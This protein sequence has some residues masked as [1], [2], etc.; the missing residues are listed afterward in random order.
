M[1]TITK[2]I[3]AA[4]GDYA[5]PAL[6]A[7]AW[8]AGTISG[9]S[10]ADDIVFEIGD[11]TRFA[12]TFVVNANPTNYASLR[13]TTAV[14]VRHNGTLGTGGGLA[15]T[16]GTSGHIVHINMGT[17]PVPATIEWL[18]ITTN[19]AKLNSGVYLQTVATGGTHTVRNN[20]IY[21]NG[22]PAAADCPGV[23]VTGTATDVHNNLIANWKSQS[24]AG[25]YAIWLSAGTGAVSRRFYNNT[26]YDI[27]CSG[28]GT[29]GGIQS[30][31]TTFTSQNNVIV[32][33][34]TTTSG[35]KNCIGGSV[36]ATRGYNATT[37]TTATGT[38]AITSIVEADTFANPGSNDF[39]PKNSASIY[40]TGLDL[41]T[42]PS[43]VQTDLKAF[44]RDTSGLAWSI[45]AYQE[46]STP[47]D[48]ISLTSPVDNQMKQRE[49]SG[50]ASFTLTGTY[51][52]AVA[53]GGIQYRWAGGA[54]TTLVATPTSGT[55]SQAVTLATGQG[56]L[57]VRLT[58]ATSV[59][60]S[61]TFVT[62]GDIYAIYGQSNASGRGVSN[63]TYSGSF[64]SVQYTGNGWQEL[65]DPADSDSW[66]LDAV[67]TDSGAAG[68][69]WCHKMVTDLM[70]DLGVPV[71]VLIV[72]KGGTSIT[73]FKAGADHLDRST[74][75]GSLN[76]HI[77]AIGGVKCV[78]WWQGETDAIAAMSQATYNGHLDSIANDLQTDRGIKL[79][80]CLL[81]NSSG[82]TD[83]NENAIRAAVTE[84]IADNANVLQGPNFSALGSDDSFHFT[85][86][87]NVDN[88]GALW[89]D[90]IIAEFFPSLT[91]V[92]VGTSSVALVG[93]ASAIGWTSTGIGSTV[94]IK[95][96]LNNGATFPIT[97]AAATANDGAYSW[98]PEA[99]HVTATGVIRVVDS[100]NAAY[101][102]DQTVIVASTA[103][104]T[105][106]GTDTALWFKLQQ[107]AIGDGMELQ[108]P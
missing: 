108:R 91:S 12:S 93:T 7:A 36:A 90:A 107:L 81:Q 54:W 40:Q 3:K 55:F 88:A 4:G 49:G 26:I 37:D 96:S 5:T 102:D 47:A 44:D 31:A 78:L 94:D 68:G 38:G 73:S 72:A 1:A 35:T 97:I 105:G 69:H 9:A 86:N 22:Q 85:S 52:N 74:L 39:R 10:A 65:T 41:G 103:P 100:A 70:A 53:G 82:I 30:V 28:S 59:T 8:N 11:A 67:A 63:R 64:R 19:G 34:G 98:T 6:A 18:E 43:G 46:G 16:T 106:G 99:A 83:A 104:A 20:L 79:M 50:N 60:D 61:A 77:N 21:N 24:T 62:V 23:R 92:T 17:N 25:A 80:S 51:N 56:T 66:Y 84:A 95:L 29:C 13:L 87:T 32:K 2:T 33:V 57:E 71:G 15:P 89:A 27:D 45:G 58:N 76:H 48:T 14:G 75:Y 101:Y 42:T